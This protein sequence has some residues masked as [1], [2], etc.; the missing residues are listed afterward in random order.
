MHWLRR[1]PW[2]MLANARLYVTLWQR[3]LLSKETP[4]S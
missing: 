1:S 2:Q 4:S 3:C